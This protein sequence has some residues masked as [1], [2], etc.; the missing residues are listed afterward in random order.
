[1]LSTLIYL[2]IL[3]SK[4]FCSCLP[5]GPIDDAQYNSYAFIAKGKVIKDTV[6]GYERIMTF[7]IEKSY[8]GKDK[9]GDVVITTGSNSAICGIAPT[10]G[11]SWLIYAYSD[12]NNNYTTGLCTRSMSLNPRVVEVNSKVV[13]A[14]FRFLEKKCK[15]QK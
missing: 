14:E 6:S 7:S 15:S 9:K 1:M 11:E 4:P 13:D 5:L 8:K 12:S 3:F 2:S 10:L